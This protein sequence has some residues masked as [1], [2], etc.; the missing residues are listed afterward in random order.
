MIKSE[1]RSVVSSRIALRGAHS[2]Q[3]DHSSDEIKTEIS[4]HFAHAELIEFTQLQSSKVGH[5]QVIAALKRERYKERVERSS[6][7]G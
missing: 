3:Q 6:L 7:Q 4:T 2:H 1:V 5:F